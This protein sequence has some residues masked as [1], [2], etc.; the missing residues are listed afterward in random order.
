MISRSLARRLEDLETR[1][2]PVVGEPKIITIEFV[3]SERNVVDRKEITV[4]APPPNETSPRAAT[5]V[6]MKN[7]RACCGATTS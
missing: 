1:M 2:L 3:D 5:M 7:G 4:T 6:A